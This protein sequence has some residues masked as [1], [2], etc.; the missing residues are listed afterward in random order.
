M[1][2]LATPARLAGLPAPLAHFV[3]VGS[4]VA[5]VAQLNVGL[6]L[7]GHPFCPGVGVGSQRSSRALATLWSVTLYGDKESRTWQC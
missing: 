1:D 2:W 5:A 3:L 4:K 7:G 6:G